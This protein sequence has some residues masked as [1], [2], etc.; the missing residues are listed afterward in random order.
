MSSNRAL[1][2]SF[3]SEMVQPSLFGIPLPTSPDEREVAWR[4]GFQEAPL[5]GHE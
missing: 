2:Q 5:Q 3:M 4:P 1:Q